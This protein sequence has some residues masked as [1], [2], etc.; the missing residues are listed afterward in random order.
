MTE[1]K[2]PIHICRVDYADPVHASA[3]VALLDAYAHDPMGGGSGLSEYAK[4]HVV[5]GLAARPQAFSVL[6]FAQDAAQTPVGLVNCIEGFST[7]AAKP[8]VNIHDVIVLHD[9]RGQGVAGAMLETVIQ[10]ARDRG[11]CKLTLEVL[12]GNKKAL[13]TYEKLGFDAYQLDPEAGSAQFLQKW[14]DA[15]SS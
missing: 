2:H 7:F 4:T 12:S 6:A 14:L 11:A 9:W 10:I 15:S 5:A 1:L 13:R 8:L 3:L